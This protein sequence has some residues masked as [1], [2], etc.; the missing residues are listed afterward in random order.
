M[1]AGAA[2]RDALKFLRDVL[3][4]AS[5][6]EGSPPVGDAYAQSND[7]AQLRSAEIVEGDSMRAVAV[8]G[9]G[10]ESGFAAF[11]D[12]AQRVQILAQ[13]D[14]VPVVFG[15]VSATIRVRVNRRLQTWDGKLP[16]VERR[17]Y[18][19]LRYVGA[20]NA[21][22]AFEIVDTSLPDAKGDVPSQHPA[23]LMERAVQRVQ[24]DREKLELKFAKSWCETES[25]ALFIDGG[26][27][28]NDQVASSLL[29]VGVV[30]SHRTLHAEGDALRVIL[31]LRAGERCSV[32]R[33]ASRSRTPVIS[34]Y[35]RL[36]GS[37]G[38]DA[39][40]GL[41]RVEIAEFSW[42]VDRVNEISRWVLRE[43]S[44]LALPD[45]RWDKMS[46]GVRDCEEFLRAIS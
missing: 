5:A 28:G 2:V 42:N 37:K 10:L 26:I 1:S 23:A 20:I 22:G 46:Y 17:L 31:N 43:A 13:N 3:P 16:A 9:D 40:W 44:P 8:V 39:M 34:W 41:V 19:P 7:P 4:D 35:L 24:Q 36:R 45:N 25:A 18:L 30:K 21:K 27:S 14:G 15:T 12:G 38:R 6:I 33:I 29:A 32:L 11:L